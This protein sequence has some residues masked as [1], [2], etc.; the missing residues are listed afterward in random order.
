[1]TTETK[2]K[3]TT[4]AGESYIEAVGRR[5]TAV[6]RVR[7]TKASKNSFRVND[8]DLDTFFP[9]KELQT[10]ATEP[11]DTSEVDAKFAVTALIKGGG[12]T[13]QAESLRHGLSRALVKYEATLRG[14]L[15]KAGYLKRDPRM[16]ERKK[17]GLK[18]A[19]KAAQWSKR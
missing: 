12:V 8:K 3:K 10:I 1:M 6:A 11:I 14:S 5:K 16:K 13:A 7:I 19:R 9:T 2:P 18:K 15:K 4:K 17:F